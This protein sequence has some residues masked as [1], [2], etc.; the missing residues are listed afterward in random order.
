VE[1][2][3]SMAPDAIAAE[4]GIKLDDWPTHCTQVAAAMLRHGLAT[5]SLVNGQATFATE[6]GHARHSWIQLTDGLM[7]DPLRYLYERREP[8]VWVGPPGPEYEP[9]PN[10]ESDSDRL[11]R[12]MRQRFV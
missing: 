4:I 8:Y 11:I 9:Q 2:F 3:E 12:T 1:R 6:Y 7:A 10:V 5:G